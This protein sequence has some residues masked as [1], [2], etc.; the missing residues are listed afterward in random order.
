MDLFIFEG[1]YLRLKEEIHR[2]CPTVRPM[3]MLRD[4][5]ITVDG[6]TIAPADA[7][8]EIAWIST[9]LFFQGPVQDYLRF[10][11]KCET[12]KWI[13]SGAAGFDN[14]VF[15]SLGQ[16][17]NLI[18]TNS[19]GAG[20][21][22]AEFVVASVLDYFQ[23]NAKRRESQAQRE[24]KRYMFRDMAE[25]NWLIFG[26]GNI[27]MEIGKRAQGFEAHVTGVR[28]NPSGNETADMMIRPDGVLDAL[29]DMDVV[30]LAAASNTANHHFV[31]SPFLAAMKD[32]AVLVNIARGALVDEVA[33]L[34]G[35]ERGR[36][37]CAILDVFETEPLPQDSPLWNHPRVRVSAHAAASSPLTGP[38]GDEV[39]LR[40]FAHY[41]AGEPLELQVRFE[42]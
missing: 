8:P 37:E 28:R 1:A 24:W 6:K 40:N 36:P 16:K 13:Q 7:A 18:Y 5:T 20:K 32:G 30:V 23:P 25:T 14:P 34:A 10:V 29:P 19:T 35:L 42:S 3:L 31:N 21:S 15:Q 17:P 26:Y 9:D 22:I 2:I 12:L 39:F 11:L 4:G 33:L 41:V 27:G 38:R